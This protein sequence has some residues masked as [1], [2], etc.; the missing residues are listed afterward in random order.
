MNQLN[1]FKMLRDEPLELPEYIDKPEYVRR[2]G[3][4]YS[5]MALGWLMWMWLFAPLL[6]LL[7]WWFEG[8][9]VYAQVRGQVQP[10]TSISLMK[11][12]L[13]IGV[14]I[15][16]LLVWAGYN[17]IRFHGRDR[18]QAPDSVTEGELARSFAIEPRD[19]VQ[20]RR[21]KSITLHY[22]DEGLLQNYAVNLPQKM[23]A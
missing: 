6:T 14:L 11:L 2:K 7:F 23:R 5:L 20:M 8:S 17:W 10:M 13:C 15:V 21:A 1:N 18:R 19:I 16:G 3:A 12:S 22:S 9:V 4:G